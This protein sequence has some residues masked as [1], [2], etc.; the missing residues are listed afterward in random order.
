MNDL[1]LNINGRNGKQ[2]IAYEINSETKKIIEDYSLN[3]SDAY[4]IKSM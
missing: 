4:P 3:A 1:E 2:I